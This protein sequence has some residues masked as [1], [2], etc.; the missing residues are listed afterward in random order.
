[1]KKPPSAVLVVAIIG[2]TLLEGLAIY[3]D[4][5]GKFFALTLAAISGIAGFSLSELIFYRKNAPERG[6]VEG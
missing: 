5:D 3:K 1:M 6:K 2:I 4:L